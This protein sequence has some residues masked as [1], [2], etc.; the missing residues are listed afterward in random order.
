MSLIGAMIK[1]RESGKA[2][3]EKLL[4]IQ[5]QRLKALVSYARENSPYYAE[6]YKDIGEDFKLGD[7]P[8]V[9]KPDMMANFDS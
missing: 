7:L 8:S 1:T 6:L 4:K 5:E 2:S 3:R 9:S